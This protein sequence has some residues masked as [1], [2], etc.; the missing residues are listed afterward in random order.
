LFLLQIIA[1]NQRLKAKNE[2]QQAEI[3]KLEEEKAK[4]E[5]EIRHG[6]P[7]KETG[8]KKKPRKKG[9]PTGG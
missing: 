7:G 4:L 3:Q 8:Q 1:E 5:A 9:P 2:K 6:K